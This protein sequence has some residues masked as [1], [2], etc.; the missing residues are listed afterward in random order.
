V[1]ELRG[2]EVRVMKPLGPCVPGGLIR[3]EA[4]AH[5]RG[6]CRRNRFFAY[7]RGPGALDPVKARLHC[8]RSRSFVVY[9]IQ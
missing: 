5:R 7:A 1:F 3:P 9:R 8:H 6:D 2:F 4:R